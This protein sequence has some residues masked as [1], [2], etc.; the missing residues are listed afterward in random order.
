M[1]T[2]IVEDIGRVDNILGSVTEKTYTV[3]TTKITL[4]DLKI[5]SSI[6]VN[7]A[8]LT[9][10][11]INGN[12]FTVEASSETLSRTNLSIL[13]VNSRVNLERALKV[14]DRLEG[15]I[16]SGHIDGLAKIV[17]IKRVG[18]SMKF[19]FELLENKLKKYFVTKGS[20]AVDGISL[21]VNE[22]VDSN[23]SINI[24]PH[25]QGAT[26]M[27]ESSIG[28]MVNIECDIIGKYIE[29]MFNY[30]SK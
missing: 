30:G 16:V 14:G 13:T 1:F 29:N 7:G 27:N 18:E 11:S 24:I 19:W 9:I 4:D 15:H 22:V 6:A 17:D 2:G 26:N 12:K 10:I 28:D 20:V 3:E 25:T 8:C 23:F 21:T 5:G